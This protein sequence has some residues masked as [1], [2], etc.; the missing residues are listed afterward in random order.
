MNDA[1]NIVDAGGK[2]TGSSKLTG[3]GPASPAPAALLGRA[4]PP[5]RD[6]ASLRLRLA[7]LVLGAAASWLLVAGLGYGVYRLVS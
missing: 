5:V 3:S 1:V 4:S 2:L 6:K 7:L